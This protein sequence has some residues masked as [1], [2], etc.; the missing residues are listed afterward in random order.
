MKTIQH[1]ISSVSLA[2][3]IIFLS[4]ACGGSKVADEGEVILSLSQASPTTPTD[5]ETCSPISVLLAWN[6]PSV[7]GGNANDISYV[8]EWGSSATNLDK[9]SVSTK[10]T[11]TTLTELAISSIC[12]WRVVSSLEG[13]TSTSATY[14]FQTLGENEESTIPSPPTNLIPLDGDNVSGPQVTLSWG[15]VSGGAISYKVYLEERSDLPTANLLVEVPPGAVT[16]TTISVNVTGGNTYYW[17]VEV[18]DGDNSNRS[19][20]WSFTVE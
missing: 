4:H 15:A 12:Y 20:I 10:D 1:K 18:L 7:I 6:A 3:F 13:K 19:N 2:I 9:K 8:V 11:K 14:Q 5:G 17:Q 16:D